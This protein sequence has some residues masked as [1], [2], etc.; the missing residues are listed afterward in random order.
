[1]GDDGL[2]R[3]SKYKIVLVAGG[4][5]GRASEDRTIQTMRACGR[6]A[7]QSGWTPNIGT[8]IPGIRGT[9]AIQTPVLKMS[10]KSFS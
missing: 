9:L 10:P 1:M 2:R 3:R 5:C 6:C 7:E 4:R 8:G